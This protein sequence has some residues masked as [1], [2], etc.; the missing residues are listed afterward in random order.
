MEGE[1]IKKEENGKKPKSL[2][3]LPELCPEPRLQVL[4]WMWYRESASGAS[5]YAVL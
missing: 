2:T 5:T 3:Q 1:G 4:N